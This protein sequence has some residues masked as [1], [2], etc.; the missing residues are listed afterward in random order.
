MN[1]LQPAW[2]NKRIGE[3]SLSKRLDGFLIKESLVRALRN[4]RQWVGCGGISDQSPI[5]LDLS[6]SFLKPRDPSKFNS[7]WLMDSNN[8]KFVNDYWH[9]HPPT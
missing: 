6:G 3:A 8:I 1:K 9:A 7:I 2:H 5:Y 4:I